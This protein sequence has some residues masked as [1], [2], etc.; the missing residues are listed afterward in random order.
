MMEINCE[1]IGIAALAIADGETPLVPPEQVEAHLSTCARCR[2]EVDQVRA[3]TALFAAQGRRQP[4]EQIW[5]LI[6]GRLQMAPVNPPS[7][8]DWR[9]VLFLGVML[10]SYKVILMSVEDDPGV[11]FRLIPVLC[12]ITVF[13]YLKENP[14]KINCELRLEGE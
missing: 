14:F 9:A 8:V 11:W 6:E 2:Q 3:V 12:V 4:E 5:T 13:A 7:P 10:L 1:S